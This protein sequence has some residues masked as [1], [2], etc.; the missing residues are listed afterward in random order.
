LGHFLVQCP[1]FAYLGY[2]PDQFPHAEYMGRSG[3]HI[4]VHQDLGIEEMD[5]VLETIGRFLESY[6][7]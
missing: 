1:G 3:I 4:G 5:Y 2:K 6:Q 7:N